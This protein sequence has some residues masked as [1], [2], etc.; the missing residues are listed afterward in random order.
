MTVPLVVIGAGGFGRETL[1]V[2]EAINAAQPTFDLLGV[3]DDAPSEVNVQRLAARGVAHLGSAA[4]W[5]A[6]SASASFIVGVGSPEVRKR[7]VAQFTAAGMTAATAVHPAAH[8]GSRVQI[9]QGSVVCAGVHISTNVRLGIHV[10]LNPNA[11]VGH[12]SQ[13][14]DYVS[15]NPGAILSGDVVVEERVLAG[16]GSVVLQGL[17]VGAGATIGASACVVRDVEPGSTVKGVPAR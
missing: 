17:R 1:D 7:I 9:G 8:I 2:V 4:D 15:V 16:A 13:L 12:D 14:D 6:S 3:I 5:I 10:H 11:T